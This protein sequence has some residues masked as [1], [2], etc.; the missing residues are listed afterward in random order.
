MAVRTYNEIRELKES[1]YKE[2]D[3]ARGKA[4]RERLAEQLLILMWVLNEKKPQV[5]DGRVQSTLLNFKGDR[6]TCH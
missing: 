1:I 2:Y 6:P 4:K 3:K 5:Y